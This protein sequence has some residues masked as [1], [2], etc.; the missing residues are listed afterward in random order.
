MRQIHLLP[1]AISCL[2]VACLPALLV[3][4]NTPAGQSNGTETFT[5]TT[6]LIE[7]DVVVRDKAGKIV[8]GLTRKDFSLT[9]AGT[10][11]KITAFSIEK[12]AGAV[13]PMPPEVPKGVISNLAQPGESVPQ[14]AA[15]ILL[16]K[17]NC[18]LHEANFAKTRLSGL[19]R[20]S[21]P[22]GPTGIL[23]LG[24]DGKLHIAANLTTDRQKL[25]RAVESYEPRPSELQWMSEIDVMDP[26]GVN[27]EDLQG[28]FADYARKVAEY[29]TEVK[30]EWTLRALDD[31]ARNLTHVPGRKSL[32]WITDAFPFSMRY[33]A[34]QIMDWRPLRLNFEPR[35]SRSMQALTDANVAMYPVDIR[36]LYGVANAQVDLQ[37]GYRE[38][39]A[40]L[41]PS[42]V[43]AHLT[44]DS[45][46]GMT[47]G[48][49]LYGRNDIDGAVREA[50]D[51][52]A[53]VYVL[54]YQP[55]HGAW[56]GSF[57]PIQVSVR[58]K[59]IR[60]RCRRG[61]FAVAAKL[62]AAPVSA[63]QR[64]LESPLDATAISLMGS[65]RQTGNQAELTL[66]IDTTDLVLVSVG[67]KW[68]GGL[69]LLIDQESGTGQPLDL[70]RLAIPFDWNRQALEQALQ[71]GV[72]MVHKLDV[73]RSAARLR[74]VVADRGSQKMGVITIPVNAAAP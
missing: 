42:I 73:S 18:R 74:I 46:A 32:I 52:A 38:S 50:L 71:H 56:D 17:L 30:I 64:A 65:A 39:C 66:A 21:Q 9:D 51:D 1:V 47:G 27:R 48:K 26:G 57:R 23:I 53:V 43:Q 35:V 45:M 31:I 54:G 6:R 37:D 36:G 11:Q 67:G 55:A 2:C 33:A 63:M 20:E 72:R 29:A 44:M 12:T 58:R 3:G 49:A 4:Q 14:N 34:K 69:D 22:A 61:Y 59:G 5:V 24:Q 7:V 25:L 13:A 28:L 40:T 62:E 70:K 15:V 60:V 68:K 10:A 16:D 8:D 19:F 41:A